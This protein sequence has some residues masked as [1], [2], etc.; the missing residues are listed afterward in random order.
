MSLFLAHLK[1]FVQLAAAQAPT[2][3]LL[4]AHEAKLGALLQ[5]ASDLTADLL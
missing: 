4:R 2:E 3:D 1:A 5:Q